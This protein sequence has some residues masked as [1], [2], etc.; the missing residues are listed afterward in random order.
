[1]PALKEYLNKNKR[2]VILIILI[3]ISFIFLFFS[4]KNAVNNFKKFGFSILYPF[5]YT[6]KSVG[7]FFENTINSISELKKSQEELTKLNQELEQY[8]KIIIDFNDMENKIKKLNEQL[9]MKDS[10]KYESEFCEIIGK[11]PENLFNIIIINKGSSSGIK[12]NMP[13]IS[14]IAGRRIL[15]G[16][17]IETISFASKVMTVQNPKLSVGA[18][19]SNGNYHTVFQGSAIKPGFAKLNYV[20][21]KYKINDSGLDIIYTS[22]DSFIFPRGIEIGRINKIIESKRYEFFNDADIEISAD[23][24]SIDYVIV[25]KV[26]YDKDDFSLYEG[27]KN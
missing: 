1:M 24:S 15:I 7:D 25:L 2:L 26:N 16:K 9:S 22:G 11:D 4:N 5:Q 23:I 12:T 8:K 21:K 6:T 20:P 18:I 14:Y 3:L 19:I 17:I 13:V 10:I 27:L